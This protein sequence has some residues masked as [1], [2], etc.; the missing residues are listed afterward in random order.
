M[1]EIKAN[2]N[3]VLVGAIA[4]AHGV[5]GGVRL[6]SFTAS[7]E[8]ISSYGPLLTEDGRRLVIKDLRKAARGFTAKLEGVSSREAAEALKSTRLYVSRDALP[9]TSEDEF[10]HADLLGLA[11]IDVCGQEAGSVIGVHDFGAGDLLEI[12]PE[13]GPS[14]FVPFTEQAVPVV[15]LAGRKVVI[16]PPPMDDQQDTDNE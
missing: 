11:V 5:K 14:F 4:G 2:P 16:D 6:V 3:L 13:E 12:A 9:E 15:D 7:S 10:Y 1:V 8:D